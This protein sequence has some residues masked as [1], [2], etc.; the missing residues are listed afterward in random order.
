MGKTVTIRVKS[1]KSEIMLFLEIFLP[2]LGLES[3]WNL[4]GRACIMKC[5]KRVHK[6]TV[7]NNRR[8]E[9]HPAL[10]IMN[11]KTEV[12]KIGKKKKKEPVVLE[13]GKII[14]VAKKGYTSRSLAS[15]GDISDRDREM[16]IRAQ[17]AVEKALE[18]TRIFGKPI[19]RYD[20]ETGT[21]Y[22]E[23]ADGRREIIE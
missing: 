19:A 22:L 17:K 7:L 20:R 2:R 10:I 14:H 12:L 15:T 6:R 8:N 11:E 16:D 23:Y 5:S 4:A 3:I 13:S 9:K 18:R 21:A 1:S